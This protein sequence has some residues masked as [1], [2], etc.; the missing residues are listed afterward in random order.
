M[1]HKWNSWNTTH[2]ISNKLYQYNK[3]T[4]YPI[5]TVFFFNEMFVPTS[6]PNIKINHNSTAYWLKSAYLPAE[7]EK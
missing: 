7:W 4:V 6:A 5:L 2:R 3:H 1:I